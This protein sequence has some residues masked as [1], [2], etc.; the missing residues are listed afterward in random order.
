M[1][2]NKYGTFIPKYYN[3]NIKFNLMNDI[4]YDNNNKLSKYYTNSVTS[5]QHILNNIDIS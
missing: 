1:V 4:R 2:L 3:F 5:L